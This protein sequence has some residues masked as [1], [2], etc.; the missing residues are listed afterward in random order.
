MK[1]K[2]LRG[3]LLAYAL[4]FSIVTKG[5]NWSDYVFST[6]IDT[7]KWHDIS[8]GSTT[9]IGSNV[10]DTATG[11]LDIGFNFFFGN[12]YYNKFSVTENGS[13][14]LG[15]IAIG[16]VGNS[17]TFGY[18]TTS[19]P[20]ISPFARDNATGTTG[21]VKYKL[22]GQ[23]PNRVLVVEYYI[24]IPITIS[25]QIQLFE[26]SNDVIMV[27]G[28][29]NQGANTYYQVGMGD[30]DGCYLIDTDDNTSHFYA[31]SHYNIQNTTIPASYRYYKY[32][33]QPA[34]CPMPIN[35]ISVSFDDAIA[36][37][38]DNLQG[39]N[40]QGY[41]VD[42]AVTGTNDWHTMQTN[43][44]TNCTIPNLL[45][46]QS[47]DINIRALCLGGDVSDTLSLHYRTACTN[48]LPIP[49]TDN[50]E[51]YTFAQTI[52]LPTCS[53]YA[54]TSST[55]ST[56]GRPTLYTSTSSGSVNTCMK[57]S[58][59]GEYYFITYPIDIMDNPLQSLQI[60]FRAYSSLP[61]NTKMVVGVTK[62][63]MN[64][65]SPDLSSFYPIDT[66]DLDDQWQQ[67]DVSLADYP[68][69][70][71]G[72]YIAM[73]CYS[74]QGTQTVYLDDV[75]VMP[76]PS[77]QRP[78]MLEVFE[79]SSTSLGL[80]WN[81]V[82]GNDEYEVVY[83]LHGLDP[84]NPTNNFY[85][86]D[87][88]VLLEDLIADT[89]YDIYVRTLCGD[90]GVSRWR[91]PLTVATGK[92][93][94]P[95]SGMVDM[96]TCN[97]MVSYSVPS[98]STYTNKS[99]ITLYSTS[100]DMAFEINGSVQFSNSSSNSMLYIFDGPDTN[101]S[102]IYSTNIVDNDINVVSSEASVTILIY[103]EYS[104]LRSVALV[105]NCVAPS[106]CSLINDITAQVDGRSALFRWYHQGDM[107]NTSAY[108][109]RLMQGETIVDSGTT[110]L[111]Y[112][113]L[114]GLS[115]D[116]LYTFMVRAKCNDGSYTQW[117][118]KTLKISGSVFIGND[119]SSYN[120]YILVAPR[121]QY[122]YS[123]QL[124]L[125][126]EIGEPGMITGLTFFIRGNN[127]AN[128]TIERSIDVYLG[129]TY[130][131]DCVTFE[132][133]NMHLVY[134]GPFVANGNECKIVFDSAFYYNGYDNLLIAVDDNSV[135]S[136]GEYHTFETHIVDHNTLY[137]QSSTDILPS[138][139][140]SLIGINTA[141]YRN[142]MLIDIDRSG[143][144][145]SPYI[146]V[147]NRDTGSIDILCTQG[148]AESHWIVSYKEKYAM[149]WVV[150][151]TIAVSDDIYVISGL[152]PNTTYHIKVEAMCNNGNKSRIITAS[153]T[154]LPITELPY[155]ESFDSYTDN[156]LPCWNT[157]SVEDTASYVVVKNNNFPLTGP[158]ALH[159]RSALNTCS[160]AILPK[161]AT[162]IDSL[163][164]TFALRKAYSDNV[165]SE[166][167]VGIVEDLDAVQT[168]Q[169][170]AIV[171]A[172][173]ASNWEY[174]TISFENY[175]GQGGY[176]ALYTR[177]R[178]TSV[179][180][181]NIEVSK[182][183]NCSRPT[184]I[185]VDNIVGTSVDVS[186]VDDN[187][188]EYIIEYGTFGFEKGS[189]TML[190]TVNTTII[191]QNLLRNT[192]YDLYV[193]SVCFDG[194]TSLYFYPISFR[195][196]CGSMMQLP[197]QENF[198]D[199]ASVS[200]MQMP[201]C[202]HYGSQ[203]GTNASNLKYPYIDYENDANGYGASIRLGTN[204]TSYQSNTYYS[205]F[206]LLP[207]DSTSYGAREFMLDFKVKRMKE[208]VSVDNKL[209]LGVMTDPDS[210][211]T[212]VCVD[213][214][215][216]TADTGVWQSFSEVNLYNYLGRGKYITFLTRTS[217]SY[218][219]DFC[220]DDIV[221]NLIPSC[222][223]P[224]DVHVTTVT[225][226]SVS[227]AWTER[228][229]ATNWVIEYGEAGFV[230]G[231][232][233]LEFTSSNPCTIIGLQPNTMYDFYVRSICGMGD[234]SNYSYLLTTITGQ[235]PATMPYS[236]DFETDDECDKW[237]SISNG[238]S[239]WNRGDAI[240]AE[241]LYSMYI[242]ADG[243]VS[244]STQN[245]IVNAS[246][247]RDI[248]F[249][250]VDTA[251]SISF[252]ARVGGNPSA[253]TD[254]LMVF[255]LDSMII[256]QSSFSPQ[257]TPW[258]HIDSLETIGRV[259]R[260]TNTYNDYYYELD[261]V[262]GV[263]RLVFFYYN[264]SSDYYVG[265]PA[266]VDDI[267]IDYISCAYP[268]NIVVN[269]VYSS[270][271]NISWT[272]SAS[273]Y[274]LYYRR[275][276]QNYFDSVYTTDNYVTLT[277]L[278]P[279]E[280]YT[281]ALRSVCGNQLSSISELGEF[282]T[283]QE[284]AQ[285][286][287]YCGFEPTESESAK[288]RL[289]N[290]NAQN[291]WCIDTAV[292]SLGN[293]SLYVSDSDGATNTCN[294]Q[295]P[296]V[297]WAYRDFYFPIVPETESFGL[298]FSW[299]CNGG[300]YRNNLKVFMGPPAE[301]CGGETITAI[302]P[303]DAVLL[304]ELNVEF[305]FDEFYIVLDAENYAG[306]IQRLY[307]CWQNSVVVSG[308]IQPP[309]VDR[310]RISS[311]VNG[312]VMPQ[313]MVDS[314]Y[315]S[316]VLSW[317]EPGRYVISY[318]QQDSDVW[319]PEVE[320][321]VNSYTINNLI[322]ATVYDYKVYKICDSVNISAWEIRSFTTLPL[323]CLPPDSLMVNDV[324]YTS[325][326]LSWTSEWDNNELWEVYYGYSMETNIWDTMVVNTPMVNLNN[327]YSGT[328][329]NVR[330]R[331]YCSVDSNFYS[332][333]GEYMFVTKVCKGV[334]NVN[335]GHRTENSAIITWTPGEGQTDWEVVVEIEGVDE[336]NSNKIRVHGT[337][338][339]Y[340]DNLIHDTLYYVYV[341]NICDTNVY[342]AW[343]EKV[344]FRSVSET[345]DEVHN[346]NKQMKLYPNP[347]ENMTMVVID[348]VVGCVDF[349]VTDVNGKT[350]VS[351]SLM[352]DGVFEKS[353]DLEQWTN[354]VYFVKVYN[355]VFTATHKLIVR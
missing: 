312:C 169:R 36:L 233:L 263:K 166:I 339:Y 181:D 256:P 31:T 143:Q 34:L 340:A 303:N 13:L 50:F 268:S 308:N 159:I 209:L 151:D 9:I 67:W 189:G 1:N 146:Y 11:L 90:G 119:L 334:D 213:T 246:I 55:S 304:A 349:I 282:V 218:I 134:S 120:Y 132:T 85:V 260:G 153:T 313:I 239:Q 139:L 330:I 217:G 345:I 172:T 88:A 331:S 271:A 108:N 6:A 286:P 183:Q 325:V 338:S 99:I 315:T 98:S 195:S 293:Y 130:M 157:Y 290:G 164:I 48:N 219:S 230:P 78:A 333:I 61:G 7:T 32:A 126:S 127:I 344:Q 154:C 152:T 89:T 275:D 274:Y 269:E 329:Y 68:I 174:H 72:S 56:I 105:V 66:L 291:K 111:H 160:V 192:L 276:N 138:M 73:R 39:Y 24:T 225:H 74:I 20:K 187:A 335:V 258:G 43:S 265:Y 103:N 236:Y 180:I 249:G 214:I 261:E 64:F 301:V 131:N 289:Y 135:S 241:G 215:Y 175:L 148:N 125:S 248:D 45:P 226:S 351:E 163:Y 54:L 156:T 49:F 14:G 350:M 168:F 118:E 324:D 326:V 348:N 266:S 41:L 70:S 97:A 129:Q 81:V 28:N 322:P 240:V 343:S 298:S 197:Y 288:W 144:C 106:E 320:T 114:S 155:Y 310:V 254:G 141:R 137:K 342:S 82:E 26:G 96:Y 295:H 259:I 176:I 305:Y 242:S 77:C 284:L 92:I 244:N 182:I 311:S 117:K 252:K 42:Y 281:Y 122:N 161:F 319:S 21:Y 257:T 191:L 318:K 113:L 234:T 71:T 124:I 46:S 316:A 296:S 110:S 346:V 76:I 247:H 23:A 253:N 221:V 224:I 171:R 354:G 307:F 251:V 300:D 250:I 4:L 27:Y 84:N 262:S 8:V 328:L 199:Y 264:Q 63:V 75:E 121:M 100:P 109:Y 102:I 19:I 142:N 198:D 35:I 62:S 255:L 18:Y 194:D 51:G 267:T 321:T 201:N 220:I 193:R 337:P 5:Q 280:R 86:M 347:A 40:P 149:Q 179:Y 83:G 202:W 58:T 17:G 206:T 93:N 104:R 190:S 177:D 47:Y 69:D 208:A 107:S 211:Q 173:S 228:N 115:F 37:Y 196:E 178:N 44:T 184:D 80:R 170:V 38:W 294:T 95:T 52:D 222:Y 10:N 327:L 285:L 306:T 279:D 210:I 302:V 203:I 57:L 2:L 355:D 133:N 22:V 323:P 79:N 238:L 223:K 353:I 272:G 167:E 91:G 33:W 158:G 229:V 162:S 227:I 205:Y 29:T 204:R 352:C 150:V 332:Q 12:S 309:V 237:Y 297:V 299:K 87:T 270:F 243:G 53:W 116:T 25:F 200:Q 147:M 188:M 59:S 65:Q 341:R 216:C 186:W 232:G 101:A 235:V 140:Q 245:T 287:Y 231:T 277:G 136:I 123:Q 94:I 30:I 128:D 314:L 278:Q 336:A 16:S 165:M 15:N 3:V 317:N 185:V 145:I 292:R 112:K 207:I 212:F 283:L 273:G 60:S